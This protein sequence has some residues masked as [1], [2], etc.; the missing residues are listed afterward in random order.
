[1]FGLRQFFECIRKASEA[2]AGILATTRFVMSLRAM[3]QLRRLSRMAGGSAA[4]P[5]PHDQIVP[6]DCLSKVQCHYPLP[7]GRLEPT[8]GQNSYTVPLLWDRRFRE[9][10]F[11]F[12]GKRK[13]PPITKIVFVFRSDKSAHRAKQEVLSKSGARDLKPV[14]TWNVDGYRITINLNDT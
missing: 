7:W 8:S 14:I 6:G 5:K 12:S 11:C 10:R 4:L 1:M 2:G 3:R 13:D 9:I